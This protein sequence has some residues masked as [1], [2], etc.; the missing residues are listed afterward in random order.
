MCFPKPDSEMKFNTVTEFS[1]VFMQKS[2]LK[3]NVEKTNIQASA[4][5]VQHLLRS[6]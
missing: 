4:V 6:S 1:F 5:L 2:S 3:L